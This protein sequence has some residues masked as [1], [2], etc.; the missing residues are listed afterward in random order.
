MTP[1]KEL[2][3]AA[4]RNAEFVQDYE[5]VLAIKS[6]STRAFGFLGSIPTRVR[7]A[8][9]GLRQ[10]LHARVLG[11]RRRV[12]Q[13]RTVPVMTFDEYTRYMNSEKYPNQPLISL[14]PSCGG[15]RDEFADGSGSYCRA[16]DKAWR[17]A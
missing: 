2:V 17:F 11:P 4:N 9:E 13:P 10:E 7:F 3:D 12:P 16:E 15:I 1:D 6:A 14:C 8:L 5:D